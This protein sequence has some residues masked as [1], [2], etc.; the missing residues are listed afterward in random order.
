LL[1]ISN[2]LSS[3]G[4]K[5]SIFTGEKIYVPYLSPL[6][7]G[8]ISRVRERDKKEVSGIYMLSQFGF[9][10]ILFLALSVIIDLLYKK[11]PNWLTFPALTAG[12]LIN[13]ITRGIEGL[14]FSIEGI[15]VGFGVL[16]IFYALGVM[17]AGDVKLMA[18]IGSFVGPKEVFMIFILATALGGVYALGL[19]LIKG[20]LWQ[21][22][23]RYG[24]IIK[25]FL[26]TLKIVYIPPPERGK[27]LKL[28]YAVAVALA[29]AVFKLSG[30]RIPFI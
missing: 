22:I 12:L 18:A 10:F 16:I 3:V 24:K 28:C 7:S 5:I 9:L 14:L 25:V 15:G 19:L 6:F 4:D 8:E 13:S 29:T 27:K 20:Y 26:F 17:G 23:K 1:Y 21:T 30:N 11:I 2:L